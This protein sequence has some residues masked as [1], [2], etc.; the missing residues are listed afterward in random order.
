MPLLNAFIDSIVCVGFN[1]E[2][3]LVINPKS[4]KNSSLFLS[5][6]QP[7]V[8]AILTADHAIYPQSK[9]KYIIDQF[10]PSI[11]YSKPSSV[12]ASNTKSEKKHIIPN[13]LNSLPLFCSP[14]GVKISHQLEDSRIHHIV[15]TQEDGK[16]SYAVVLTFQEKFVLKT[17]TSYDDGRYQIESYTTKTM[18][19]KKS[20]IP[21]HLPTPATKK[22]KNRIPSSYLHENN[23]SNKN[24]ISTG[25]SRMRERSHSNI[26]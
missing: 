23:T 19:L 2:R 22:P 4:D 8:L 5:L 24:N 15:F 14:D 12:F 20:Q 17:E 9:E 21:V 26:I 25:T 6:L 13:A 10:Y 3:G 18:Q 11:C 1:S 16:R 7:Y